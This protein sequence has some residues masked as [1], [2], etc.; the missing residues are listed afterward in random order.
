MPGAAPAPGGAP[1]ATAATASEQ[2]SRQAPGVPTRKN[3]FSATSELRDVLKSIPPTV[4]YKVPEAI[5][6]THDIYAELNPPEPPV[7]VSDDE[8][9]GPPVPPMRVAGFVEGAQ[10]SA[11]IQLGS[12]P[13]A[14]FEQVTPGK[15]ITFRG[16]TYK[17]ERL[18]QNKVILV[19]NWEMGNR[20]GTQ[21]IEVTLSGG[22][23]SS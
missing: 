6:P 20:T 1:A 12:P 7:S 3:P 14:R 5:S 4:D 19:N 22:G 18:E 8:G 23:P 15:S 16:Q 2:P 21:R 9:E 13:G 10:L 11:T 17:V